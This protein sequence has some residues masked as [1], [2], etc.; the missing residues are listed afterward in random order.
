MTRNFYFRKAADA[1]AGSANFAADI[2]LNYASLGLTTAQSAAFGVV[3]TALQA[4]WTLA[5]DPSTRTRVTIAG[6]DLALRNMRHAAVPLAKI[7]YATGTVTDAQLIGL[8]LLPRASFAPVGPAP[9]APALEV[10]AVTG[11]RVQ[12]RLRP[13]GGEGRPAIFPGSKGANVYSF[14]GPAAPAE[15]REWHFEGLATR[16]NAQ[17][18]FPDDVPSGATV[19]LSACWVS[20][21]GATG[22]A[23]EPVPFTLQGGGVLP[24]AA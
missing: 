18:L 22:P 7:I 4:A 8:G 10:G 3:N 23:C 15:Q 6:K 16:G 12:I 24:E 11:R 19:W 17:V 5:T 14:V 1:V 9:T 2:A 21:R 13:A 20:N